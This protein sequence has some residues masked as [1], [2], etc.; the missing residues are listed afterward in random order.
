MTNNASNGLILLIFLVFILPGCSSRSAPAPVVNLGTKQQPST[1]RSPNAKSNSH[2]VR[3]GDTLYSIAFSSGKDFLELAKINH[4]SAPYFI[5]PGQQLKLN[6]SRPSQLTKKTT[7]NKTTKQKKTAKPTVNK[8]KKIVPRKAPPKKNHTKNSNFPIQIQRWYWP[9]KGD[10]VSK[11]SLAPEGNK[12]I[13]IVNK[14]GS[15]ITA[16]ADGKVVYTGN[17]LRGY[18]K[19]I[20]VKH[21]DAFLSAYAHNDSIIV[22]EQQWVKA[23]QKIGHMG[24]TGSENVK[25]HFEIRYKGKSVDPLRYLPAR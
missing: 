15:P 3:K 4:I 14:K 18:G 25:L 2:I 11:F 1:F 8:P 9:T 21:S 7:S 19:L 13:D 23:G 5:Y 16:A 10:I 12:G 22:K 6:S 20:I 24:K 17:A